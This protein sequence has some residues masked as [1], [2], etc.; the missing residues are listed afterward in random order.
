VK[1]RRTGTTGN[2]GWLRYD[3][4]TTHLY[5]TVDPYETL[6]ELDIKT[7]IGDNPKLDFE[8]DDFLSTTVD[9]DGQD[10]EVISV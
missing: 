7:A 10:W 3:V 4:D 8:E 9:S 6:E 2:A 1:C 5:S